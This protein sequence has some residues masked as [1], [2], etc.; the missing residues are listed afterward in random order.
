MPARLLLDTGPVVAILDGDDRRHAVCVEAVDAFHGEFVTS[1]AVV[2]EACYMLSRLP[3]GMVRCLDFLLRTE[4]AILPMDEPLLRRV[5]VM[6][7]KYAD[8]PM[9]YADATLVAIAEDLGL[10]DVFTLDR[11][12]FTV[13]RALDREPFVILPGD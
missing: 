6:L 1:E 13:Y 11:K 12:G 2:T 3:G 10:R 7:A 8:L 5:M 4:T 9:D